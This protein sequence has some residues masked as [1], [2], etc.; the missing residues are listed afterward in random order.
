MSSTIAIDRSEIHQRAYAHWQ[1]RGCPAGSPEYD[2]Y[3]AEQE[4]VRERAAL[5]AASAKLVAVVDALPP[6]KAA[7]AQK[8]RGARAPRGRITS[9][10]TLNA[11]TAS[12]DA[13]PESKTHARASAIPRPSK[14]R[15][16][17]R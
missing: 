2:W 11:A 15:K 17:A 6:V 9:P 10:L 12:A 5:E 4:L 7:P 16:V 8:K 13:A 3:E 14:Q 1:A